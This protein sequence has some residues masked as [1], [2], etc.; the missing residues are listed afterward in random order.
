M[1]VGLVV[2]NGAWSLSRMIK[3]AHSP[4]TSLSS[5][6][7]PSVLTAHACILLVWCLSSLLSCF[8]PGSTPENLLSLV[9]SMFEVAVVEGCFALRSDVPT[10]NFFKDWVRSQWCLSQT[11]CWEQTILVRTKSPARDTPMML[12]IFVKVS[13]N[14]FQ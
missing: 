10:R 13:N 2:G 7:A 11:R 8:S 9:L 12:T 1:L 4:V 3:E 5:N 6:L 14:T